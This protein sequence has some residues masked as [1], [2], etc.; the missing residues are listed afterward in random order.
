MTG[1]SICEEKT[2]VCVLLRLHQPPADR[3]DSAM[4]FVVSVSCFLLAH[5]VPSLWWGHSE[6]SACPTVTHT[7]S[8]ARTHTNTHTLSGSLEARAE[9]VFLL[10]PRE[11]SISG[12]GSPIFGLGFF[13]NVFSARSHTSWKTNV[14]SGALMQTERAVQ[15]LWNDNTKSIQSCFQTWTPENVCTM[16][17]RHSPQFAF[18]VWR[19]QQE[20]LQSDTFTTTQKS[21]KCFGEGWRSRQRQDVT[22]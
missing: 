12:L 15:P 18:H 6:A 19:T 10:W 5:T 13:I 4:Q 20:I 14:L 17:S 11:V 9:T 22:N 7:H 1:L 3:T 16:G 2:C 8:H 21:P